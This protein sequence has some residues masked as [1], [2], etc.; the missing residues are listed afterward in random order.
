MFRRE[1]WKKPPQYNI[2]SGRFSTRVMSNLRKYIIRS[3]YNKK[4]IADIKNKMFIIVIMQI[5]G[6]SIFE[7]IESLSRVSVSF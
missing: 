5:F 2:I 3:N 6:I 1:T 4:F 7:I